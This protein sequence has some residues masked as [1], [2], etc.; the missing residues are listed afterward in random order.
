MIT[1][2]RMERR[3]YTQWVD[4]PHIDAI[5]AQLLPKPAWN[6]PGAIPIVQ[7]PHRHAGCC[8]FAQ[9]IGEATPNLVGFEDVIFEMHPALGA[10]DRGEPIV[11]GIRSILEQG[12]CIVRTKLRA[13]YTTQ[14]T[15]Q[16][17]FAWHGALGVQV[18][19]YY[20][21]RTRR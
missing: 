1:R 21:L 9:S 14:G 18:R 3:A 6:I 12:Q 20:R 13:T 7:H 10:T 19:G 11:E 16:A 15:S 4:H 2:N 17:R 8:P 5:V